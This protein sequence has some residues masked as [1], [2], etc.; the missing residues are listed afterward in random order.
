MILVYDL[1]NRSNC[2][3]LECPRSFPIASLYKWDISYLWG[4]FGHVTSL[5]FVKIM[6][7]ISETV[8]QCKI[9]LMLVFITDH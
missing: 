8:Q 2:N 4:E 5:N 9:E 6:D 3:D 1:S 7:N